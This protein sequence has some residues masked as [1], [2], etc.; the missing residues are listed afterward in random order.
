M[1]QVLQQLQ[2]AH[3]V[4]GSR[5][6]QGMSRYLFVVLQQGRWRIKLPDYFASLGIST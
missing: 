4:H 5:W 1:Q 6:A 3:N 2:K